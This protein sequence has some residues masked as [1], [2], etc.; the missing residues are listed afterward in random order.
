MEPNNVSLLDLLL[1]NDVEAGLA[2]RLAQFGDVLLEG[3]RKCNLTSARTPELL[4][5]HLLD[6]LTC[7]GDVDGPLVDIGSGGGFP[8]IPIG[9]ATGV[10]ITLI[11][12][13][14][15]K[16]SFLSGAIEAL[17]MDGNVLRG[18][19]ETFALQD[20]YRE[21]FRCATARAVGSAPTVIEYVLP[22]LSIGGTAILQRGDMSDQERKASADAALVLG[23]EL[24]EERLLGGQRR[25]LIIRKVRT[26]A[27]RFP[28]KNGAPEKRPLCM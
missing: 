14:A 17:G 11:E 23:G 1:Q 19:A 12:S 5:P 10:P 7:V 3:N 18:R 22:F 8:A 6:S 20:E 9:L 25:I 2:Q 27:W 24:V 28:R 16:T 13:I 4:L 21:Q 26:T 15:K